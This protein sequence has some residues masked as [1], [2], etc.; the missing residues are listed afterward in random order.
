MIPIVQT[1]L[2]LGH[3]QWLNLSSDRKRLARQ[4][5]Q[6]YVPFSL[7]LKY[8]PENYRE[9]YKYCHRNL[10]TNSLTLLTPSIKLYIWVSKSKIARQLDYIA[11]LA[12]IK[13]IFTGKKFSVG[14]WSCPWWILMKF[15]KA[16]FVVIWYKL[17]SWPIKWDQTEVFTMMIF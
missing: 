3:P 14:H 11:D 4:Q 5:I 15:G 7:C 8:L 12:G 6:T 9:L 16:S 10:S 1:C 2:K 13:T 17:I